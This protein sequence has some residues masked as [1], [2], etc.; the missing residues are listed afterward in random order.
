[1]LFDQYI[2]TQLSASRYK[3]AKLIPVQQSTTLGECE[4]LIIETWRNAIF[5]VVF[6]ILVRMN[7]SMIADVK[8]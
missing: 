6:S 2:Y 8:K 7:S 1:M 3:M 5:G 4:M